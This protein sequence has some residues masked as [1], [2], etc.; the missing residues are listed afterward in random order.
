MLLIGLKA[1][2]GLYEHAQVHLGTKESGYRNLNRSYATREKCRYG[3]SE[4]VQATTSFSAS[5]I[6]NF[7][8][9]TKFTKQK[10]LSVVEDQSK[11]FLE[12]RLKCSQDHPVLMFDVGTSRGWLVPEIT[13][14][15]HLTLA[16][17]SR[18]NDLASKL[19]LLP[20]VVEALGGEASFS[21]IRNGR[22]IELREAGESLSGLPQ[23]FIDFVMQILVGFEKRKE[24]VLTSDP[25]IFP[26]SKLLRR[27]MLYGW[28]VEDII[29]S[30]MFCE[31]KEVV[32]DK[33][34]GGWDL[35]SQNRPDL[36]VLLCQGLGEPIK[37]SSS[38]PHCRSWS[39]V[40]A[41]Y[42]YM[43]ATVECLQQLAKNYACSV[44]KSWELQL[45]PDLSWHRPSEGK[46]FEKCSSGIGGCNRLQEV[47]DAKHANPP[48]PLSANG[49][50][51]TVYIDDYVVL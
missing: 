27:P 50:V 19:D 48:G 33:T 23:Y 7:T 6:W 38:S 26:L 14:L 29:T 25:K 47:K 4:K 17:I 44:S 13:A 43:V 16:S 1:F 34:A 21:A 51:V 18:E 45:A 30:P 42:G 41:G 20:H 35:I 8:I 32:L 15:L 3:L 46:L 10:G 49:A 39:P 5:G 9:G 28:D 11:I 24:K 37:P 31:R 36:L 12:K 2:L 40:P 22:D